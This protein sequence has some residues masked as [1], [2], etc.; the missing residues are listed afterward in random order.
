M[1]DELGVF[2]FTHIN[3]SITNITHAELINLRS[4]IRARYFA[5][6]KEEI[7]APK[8]SID[9]IQYTDKDAIVNKRK[10]GS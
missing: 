4:I 8:E 6:I 1:P 7:L 2:H 3:F 10:K 9:S 5:K